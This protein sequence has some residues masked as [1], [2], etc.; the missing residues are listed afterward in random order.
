MKFNKIL[1]LVV[2]TC[3]ITS[4]LMAGR[5]PEP[6]TD[7]YNWKGIPAKEKRKDWCENTGGALSKRAEELAQEYKQAESLFAPYTRRG[8]ER[9]RTIA[10]AVCDFLEERAQRASS[11]A[12][13]FQG[14]GEEGPTESMRDTAAK[15]NTPLL[16][17]GRHTDLTRKVA[18]TK[19]EIEKCQTTLKVQPKENEKSTARLAV[20]Q[21][22]A[23]EMR[24]ALA[25]ATQITGER[26]KACETT[27]LSLTKASEKLQEAQEN[28]NGLTS[29]KVEREAELFPL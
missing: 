27:E 15:M 14:Y 3:L 2:S 5:T 10:N 23:E 28:L 19:A 1:S 17:F 21:K 16:T 8:D 7:A 9:V 12:M 26:R 24:P 11:A 18:E 22:E 20:L 13:Y 29:E 6:L 4:P 25:K